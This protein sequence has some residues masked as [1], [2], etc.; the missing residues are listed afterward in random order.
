MGSVQVDPQGR[1]YVGTL[2]RSEFRYSVAMT[3]DDQESAGAARPWAWG[4]GAWGM[5]QA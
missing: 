3:I 5:G 2:G 4:V 1:R